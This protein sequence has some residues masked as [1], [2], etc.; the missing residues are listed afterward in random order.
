MDICTIANQRVAILN[1]ICLL[2]FFL[3]KSVLYNLRRTANFSLIVFQPI[4]FTV[5][6]V[7]ILL[8]NVRSSLP[9]LCVCYTCDLH[10]VTKWYKLGIRVYLMISGAIISLTL[11][12]QFKVLSC[13]IKTFDKLPNR[14]NNLQS[15]VIFP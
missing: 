15:H 1:L 10:N 11:I 12:S 5:C 13:A 14:G 3:I 9:F 2:M 7:T 4:H 8:L 6:N